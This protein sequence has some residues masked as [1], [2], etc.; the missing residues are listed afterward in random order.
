MK[1]STNKQFASVINSNKMNKRNSSD[2]QNAM[3]GKSDFSN[4]Y[5]AKGTLLISNM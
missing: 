1:N 5:Q 4:N 3:R 2:E